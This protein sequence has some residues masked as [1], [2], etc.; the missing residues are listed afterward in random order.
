MFAVLWC[1]LW[2]HL[3]PDYLQS[4]TIPV[5]ACSQNTYPGYRRHSVRHLQVRYDV[6]QHGEAWCCC[7][8]SAVSRVSAWS[9]CTKWTY[10]YTCAI[11]GKSTW[12]IYQIIRVVCKDFNMVCKDFNMQIRYVGHSLE[13]WYL[14][15]LIYTCRSYP[16]ACWTADTCRI[17]LTPQ[18]TANICW[19]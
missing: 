3:Q 13:S 5:P 17:K 18:W 10:L 8:T 19:I 12:D 15:D 11:G 7:T 6:L 4:S 1:G 9:T 16:Y 14:L 2:V